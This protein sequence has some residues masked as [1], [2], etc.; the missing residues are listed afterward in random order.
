[1]G[2]PG[3]RATKGDNGDP[4]PP[5]DPGPGGEN[6]YQVVSGIVINLALGQT[7]GAG[8]YCPAG[9]IAV[10]GGFSTTLSIVAV[11]SRPIQTASGASG[12]SRQGTSTIMRARSRRTRSA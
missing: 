9:K 1:M 10:S 5:G 12:T 2:I 6:G 7:T 3:R 4:G 8:A 11:E